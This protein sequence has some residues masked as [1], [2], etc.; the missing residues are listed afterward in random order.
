[1]FRIWQL[2]GVRT[3]LVGLYAWLGFLAIM[4]HLILLSTDR[5]NWMD[6]PQA[7]KAGK[8]AEMSPMPSKRL[9]ANNG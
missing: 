7:N 3:V 8:A 9:A 6:G 1:M 2:F 5:Y 4:I